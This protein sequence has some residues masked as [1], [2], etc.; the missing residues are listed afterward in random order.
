MREGRGVKVGL[1]VKKK[2]WGHGKN[3][4]VPEVR[5]RCERDEK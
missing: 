4:A 1:G 2:E 5:K 3:T